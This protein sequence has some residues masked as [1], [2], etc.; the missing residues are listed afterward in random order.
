MS[1]REGLA[2]IINFACEDQRHEQ[3]DAIIAALPEMIPN[4][5]VA[6]LSWWNE[7]HDIDFHEHTGMYE[8]HAKKCFDAGYTRALAAFT[9]ETT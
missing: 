6:F 4:K 5:D 7:T 8:R 9:G 3:A 2:D 1:I